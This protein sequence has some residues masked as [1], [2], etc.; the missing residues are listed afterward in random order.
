MCVCEGGGGGGGA[1]KRGKASS[2]GWVGGSQEG[3]PGSVPRGSNLAAANTP[4]G[5]LTAWPPASRPVCRWCSSPPSL[6]PKVLRCAV[7][8]AGV[9]AMQ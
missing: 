5:P 4:L 9:Q 7:H 1:Q 3:Q 2:G 8:S 6:A